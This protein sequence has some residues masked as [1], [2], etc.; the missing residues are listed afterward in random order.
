MLTNSLPLV[1]LVDDDPMCHDMIDILKY[2]T[3]DYRFIKAFNGHQA[4]EL[5]KKFGDQIKLILL[6]LDLQDITGYELLEIIRSDRKNKDIQIIIQ[7]GFY[8]NKSD[9]NNV[10]WLQKP[11]AYQDLLKLIN[12]CLKEELARLKKTTFDMS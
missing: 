10:H 7:T 8:Y 2:E 9:Y 12:V 1:L 4:L 11:Y 5:F 3:Q 6:D